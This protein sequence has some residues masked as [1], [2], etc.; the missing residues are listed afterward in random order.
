MYLCCP[1]TKQSAYGW[2]VVPSMDCEW[3]MRMMSLSM[4][5]LPGSKRA[6]I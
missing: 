6:F 2:I 1:F 3:L 4:M 5:H